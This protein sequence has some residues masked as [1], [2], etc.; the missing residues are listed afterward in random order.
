MEQILYVGLEV[1]DKSFHAAL[2]QEESGEVFEIKTKPQGS[3]LIK[4]FKEFES[5]GFTLKICYE[6]T[7]LGFSSV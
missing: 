5:K 3:V 4:K 2:M 6:A 7:F 1:D